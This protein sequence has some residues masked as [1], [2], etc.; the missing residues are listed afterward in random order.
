MNYIPSQSDSQRL[1]A[2]WIMALQAL[3]RAAEIEAAAR[4]RYETATQGGWIRIL[5][6]PPCAQS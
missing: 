6:E 4:K 5:E 2:E 1:Y 3:Q